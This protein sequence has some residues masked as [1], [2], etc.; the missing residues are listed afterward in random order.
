M[1]EEIDRETILKDFKKK[2][3]APIPSYWKAN[4]TLG[5][6]TELEYYSKIIVGQTFCGRQKF[7]LK[8]RLISEFVK[9]LKWLNDGF[10]PYPSDPL[11]ILV[12]KWEEKLK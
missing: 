8:Q 7:R 11:D 4:I 3:F 6:T 5:K 2:L 1:N 9:D 12:K 10:D